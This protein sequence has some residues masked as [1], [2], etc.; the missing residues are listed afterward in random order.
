MIPAFVDSP[1]TI[2]AEHSNE[3]NPLH[4]VRRELVRPDDY[5]RRCEHL[6]LHAP[7]SFK[8]HPAAPLIISTDIVGAVLRDPRYLPLLPIHFTMPEED[9]VTNLT[10][11]GCYSLSDAEATYPAGLHRC[12]PINLLD[13]C[14]R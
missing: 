10:A 9:P 1:D 4:T 13:V 8:L 5:V 7:S 14:S 6:S 3:F 11:A 2:P 12:Q